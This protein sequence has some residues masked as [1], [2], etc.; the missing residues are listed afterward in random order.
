MIN[1][2]WSNKLHD[3]KCSVEWCTGKQGKLKKWLCV[4]HY[5]RLRKHWNVWTPN[6]IDKVNFNWCSYCWEKSKFY[7][8]WYCQLHYRR[9]ITWKGM[10]VSIF[11]HHKAIIE[12]DIAKLPLWLNW[13]DWFAIVDKEFAYLDKYRWKLSLWYAVT[14]K[15]DNLIKKNINIKLHHVII[16]KASDGNVIDHINMDRLDNRLSNLRKCSRSANW[17]NRTKT[18]KNTSWYKWVS[19]NKDLWKYQAY[20]TVNKKRVHLWYFTE[21]NKANEARKIAEEKF[22]N[23]IFS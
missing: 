19:L 1:V 13:K 5:A 3:L 7:M 18:V 4:M 9:M 17:M 23:L 11:S 12:W 20:I 8:K 15:K 21:A 22:Y 2:Q 14:Q 6:G 16:G 10:D